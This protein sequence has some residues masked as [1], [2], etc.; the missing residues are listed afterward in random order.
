MSLIVKKENSGVQEVLSQTLDS[1]HVKLNAMNFVLNST[2][3]KLAEAIE[4]Y[5]NIGGTPMLT[6]VLNIQQ[7]INMQI[8][9]MREDMDAIHQQYMQIMNSPQTQ[10]EDEED[11][12][13]SE[14]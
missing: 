13:I 3:S 2:I 5:G 9:Q 10:D 12:S 11:S 6:E 7:Q 8:S 1:M 14:K 4:S